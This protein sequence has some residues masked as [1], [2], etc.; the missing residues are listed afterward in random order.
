MII[1][2]LFIAVKNWNQPK[3]QTLKEQL[4]QSGIAYGAFYLL[5][6]NNSELLA[7]VAGIHKVK[8]NSKIFIFLAYKCLPTEF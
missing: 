3:Y 7:I 2:M 4:N 5:L 8:D 1:E 6:Y